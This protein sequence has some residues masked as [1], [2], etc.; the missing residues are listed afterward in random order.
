MK[1]KIQIIG[2]L[3]KDPEERVTPSGQKVTNFSVAA[4]HS[5]TSKDGEKMKE[6]TWFRV[7]TW[8]KLADACAD[9]L[10]KGT[11]V[12]VEGRIKPIRIYTKQDG[13][14]DAQLEINASSVL[15]LSGTK[16][17]NESGESVE[18]TAEENVPF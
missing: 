16:Q 13:T 6:T 12:E 1:N 10:K 9:W 7:E 18:Q 5:Y 2:H 14:A 3:G 17:R 8:G 4:T 15:F 11:L